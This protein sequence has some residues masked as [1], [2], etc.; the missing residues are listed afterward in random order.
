MFS[1]NGEK[2]TADALTT[3][4]FPM[5]NST[6]PGISSHLRLD[7]SKIILRNIKLQKHSVGS[8]LDVW[9]KMVS[10]NIS[11]SN[12][13]EKTTI[14]KYLQFKKSIRSLVDAHLCEDR[15]SGFL[16]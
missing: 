10:R 13:T 4:P 12:L 6:G 16:C 9:I 2:L 1:C 11:M 15:V 7:K 14:I 8:A 5:R 3:K